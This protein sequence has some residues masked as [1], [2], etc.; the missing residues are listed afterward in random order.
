[1]KVVSWIALVLAVAALFIGI[2]NTIHIVDLTEQV[3]ANTEWIEETKVQMEKI[4]E[5]FRQLGYALEDIGEMGCDI[6]PEELDRPPLKPPTLP[7]P[8]PPLP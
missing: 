8:K 4:E 1:M 3:K 2:R 6:P 7:P 5:A